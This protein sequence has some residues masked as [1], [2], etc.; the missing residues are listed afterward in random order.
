[1]LHET[2]KFMQKYGFAFV[3]LV[4]SITAIFSVSAKETFPLQYEEMDRSTQ[5]ISDMIKGKDNAIGFVADIDGDGKVE[6]VTLLKE[7]Y[8]GEKFGDVTGDLRT[9]KITG[10]SSEN[11]DEDQS[12]YNSSASIGTAGG[13]NVV[14]LVVRN[15]A[16]NKRKFAF[17]LGEKG[18][19][20]GVFAVNLDDDPQSEFVVGSGSAAKAI[21]K[22]IILNV[23]GAGFAGVTGYGFYGWGPLDVETECF[24]GVDHDGTMLWK[25]EFETKIRKKENRDNFYF[26]HFYSADP[27]RSPLILFAM[28]N[29][30][31]FEC[32][33]AE[34]GETI[35]HKPVQAEYDE[36]GNVS[37]IRS[38]II[39]DE[40]NP[41]FAVT[42][43]NMCT[44]YDLY[45][46]RQLFSKKLK[47][48]AK[49]VLDKYISRNE[50]NGILIIGG[51]TWKKIAVV[52]LDNNEIWY[53]IKTP[54]RSFMFVADVDDDGVQ[55]GV[56]YTKGKLVFHD[57]QTGVVESEMNAAT[58]LLYPIVFD[59][60]N[61]DTYP[62]CLLFRT[63]NI[64]AIDLRKKSKCWSTMPKKW[65]IGSS[66]F[67]YGAIF[68]VN[69]DGYR[70][71]FCQ[72][73]NKK[74][75]LSGKDGQVLLRLKSNHK[76]YYTPILGDWDN[77][78]L[79][80]VFWDDIWFEL[81]KI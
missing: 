74:F 28:E 62:E 77:D 22:N 68:D 9:G 75:I 66:S 73:G 12:G 47:F 58:A 5:F 51:A 54:K 64:T 65:S 10:N 69:Q 61:N 42:S 16:D 3:I 55:E 45:N 44:V 27:E 59:Y 2:P 41:L 80:E 18:R 37:G 21:A 43:G 23:V 4:M 17:V 34:T 19:P 71:I 14:K 38:F 24:Y 7:D 26:R 49:F 81:T 8:L 57:L 35:W 67:I 48:S 63:N 60:V 15:M 13:T 1:M 29:N 46:G 31:Y 32:L 40:T 39:R 79:T 56:Y 6:L 76:Y 33:S 20:A 36:E 70:E 11:N 78:G 30:A 72:K 25:T 50:E 53:Q 52:S